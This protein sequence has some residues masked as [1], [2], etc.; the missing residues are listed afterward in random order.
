MQK[1]LYFLNEEEK[2][3]I[4]NLHES[5]TKKQYLVNEQ[6]VDNIWQTPSKIIS[7]YQTDS[8]WEKYPCVTKAAGIKKETLSDGTIGY[9]GGGYR[10]YNNGR[11]QNL[12]TNEM[13]NYHCGK[14]GKVKAGLPP[15]TSTDSVVTPI[16]GMGK[17]SSKAQAEIPTLL[18][19][20]GLEGTTLTQ[21]AVNKLYNKLSKKA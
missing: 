1:K 2:N 4:L 15:T 20:V 16:S 19:Q 12:T 5:R 8:K 3:R 21:D 18:K 14:D 6:E 10:W 9:V 7:G 17:V 11:R 13:D